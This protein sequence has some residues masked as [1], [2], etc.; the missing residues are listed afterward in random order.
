MS[1]SP[2]N[3]SACSR[4]VATTGANIGLARAHAR[5]A[6]SRASAGRPRWFNDVDRSQSTRL[7][8][9]SFSD[10]G[11]M[12][13][14]CARAD[15]ASL[16][17]SATSAAGQAHEREGAGVPRGVH[18]EEA[19]GHA[20]QALGLLG[21]PGVL[22]DL[23]HAGQLTGDVALGAERRHGPLEV[24]RGGDRVGLGQADR[25]QQ[26]GQRSVGHGGRQ[27]PEPPRDD[28]ARHRRPG[29]AHRVD[30]DP[31]EVVPGAGV[32]EEADHG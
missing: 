4:A 18:L 24:R 14:R 29:G 7:C 8:H 1:T 12:C 30:H 11:G 9:T 28:V 3:Q 17:M 13:A 31:G 15:A 19:G 25:A 10:P 32:G 20:H 27:L 21:P 22:D 2:R 16:A 23:G 5:S 6:A 26:P